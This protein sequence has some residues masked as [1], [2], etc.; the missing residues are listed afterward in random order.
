MVPSARP[1]Q[2][3]GRATVRTFLIADIR[4]YTAFTREHGDEAAGRLAGRF[5]E[6]A[7]EAAA[8]RGG[9]VLELRGDE[10]LAVFASPAQAVRAGAEL[11]QACAEETAEDQSLPL[12]VGIGIDLGD[13]VPVEGGFR[14]KALNTAA[15]LCS[16][17]TAGEMLLT[18]AVAEAVGRIDGLRLD[19]RGALELKGFDRPVEVVRVV[20]GARRAPRG[21]APG[22]AVPSL[23]VELDTFT[24]LV[25]RLDEMRWLRGTWRQA[26]RGRG[27]LLFVS[28]PPGI[29]KTRLVAEI[30]AEIHGRT[31]LATYS[32]AGGAGTALTLQA[33]REAREAMHPSIV[34]VDD[35][36]TLGEEVAVSLGESVVAIADAPSSSLRR[37]VRQRGFPP[38]PRSS[39]E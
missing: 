38:S 12:T 10:A 3:P 35:V 29:G 5:A 32:G 16:S 30:A 36:E 31:G 20:P 18:T 9:E 17:A 34:V 2:D 19:E 11:L 7:R 28:G 14:G 1:E 27:C 23:A 24:P 21:L 39:S 15:R 22:E 26:R 33:I 4:G 8:A 6:V 37:S 13:A 25:D